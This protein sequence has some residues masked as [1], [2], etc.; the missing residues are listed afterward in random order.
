[1][2][3]AYDTQL[4][5]TFINS[6]RKPG[7]GRITGLQEKEDVCVCVC[8]RVRACMCEGVRVCVRF[9]VRESVMLRDDKWRVCLSTTSS[10]LQALTCSYAK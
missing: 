1:M 2:R 10:H 9:S 6:M 3:V 7:L 5:G 4:H 8:V